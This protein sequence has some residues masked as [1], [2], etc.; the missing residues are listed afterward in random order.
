MSELP[1]GWSTRPLRD[2][3]L[4]I[5]KVVP[6]DTGRETIRYIDIG[7]V[8]GAR[9]A[10]TDVQEIAAD[11]APSRARQVVAAGDTVFSTVRPYLEKIAYVDDSL[12]SEFASTGFSVLRPSPDLAPKYLYYFSI[13]RAMLDQILPLQ[14][15]V[16]YP[17][18]LDKEV[19]AAV[20]PVPPLVEQRRI[21][22]ILEDH[23]SRIDTGEGLLRSVARRG[24]LLELASLN[25]LVPEGT[26][27][28]TLKEIA[29]SAGYGTSTKCVVDGPGVPVARIPN[30]VNGAIDLADE[31]RAED[32]N[33]DLSEL[34]L[35]EGDLLFVRTN[36]SRDLIGRT[37]VAQRGIKASFASYLIRYQLDPERVEASWVHYMMRRP[38]AR[39]EIERLASS[40]AGQLNLSLAKLDKVRV[41]LPD[42]PTQR[43]L[44]AAYEASLDGPRRLIESS[45]RAGRQAARLRRALLTAAFSGKLTGMDIDDERVEEMAGV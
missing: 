25:L 20:V 12:D 17:A 18:V 42:L 38:Q 30:V 22:E 15:G 40:S 16:S 28:V 11:G 32:P 14:K 4:P 37:A 6:I 31:K 39:A 2:L 5:T 7:S 27:T 1:A 26:P 36:G 29:V 19:R 44:I 13:S 41:P 9:H 3:T 34:M 45:E 8:S 35:R 23:F 33:V 24:D 43:Q 21:V 10:L